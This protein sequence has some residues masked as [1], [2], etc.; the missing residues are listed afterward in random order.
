MFHIIF[1]ISAEKSLGKEVDHFLTGF[2]YRCLTELLLYV[3]SPPLPYLSSPIFFFPF[4]PLPQA[5]IFPFQPFGYETS[6]ASNTC[7]TCQSFCCFCLLKPSSGLLKLSSLFLG[8]QKCKDS[9]RGKAI[10]TENSLH[11]KSQSI[12]GNT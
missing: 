12:S 1:S 10:C 9:W 11:A 4:P 2:S 3:P 6:L 8:T 5:H 7:S